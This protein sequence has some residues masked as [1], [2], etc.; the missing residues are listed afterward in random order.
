VIYIFPLIFRCRI[1]HLVVFLIYSIRIQHQ[2]NS[3]ISNSR[4]LP[5]KINVLYVEIVQSFATLIRKFFALFFS[6]KTQYPKRYLPLIIRQIYYFKIDNKCVFL[7]QFLVKYRTIDQ[8]TFL[9][10]FLSSFVLQ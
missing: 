10:F 8:S 2:V 6:Q 9:L 4:L 1:Y 3:A 5:N 7:F